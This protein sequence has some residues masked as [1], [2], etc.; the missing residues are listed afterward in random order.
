VGSAGVVVVLA[1]ALGTTRSAGS[2]ATAR[3]VRL[4]GL[5]GAPVLAI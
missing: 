4:A 2:A 5:R 1:V 3:L